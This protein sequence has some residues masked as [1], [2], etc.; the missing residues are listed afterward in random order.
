MERS[1]RLMVKRVRISEWCWFVST[2]RQHLVMLL[3]RFHPLRHQYSPVTLHAGA[4]A[5]RRHCEVLWKI[6]GRARK[7]DHRQK[8]DGS[9][10]PQAVPSLASRTALILPALLFCRS[11]WLHVNA[12]TALPKV[13]ARW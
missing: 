1:R 4:W 2:F 8:N 9:T 3:P 5:L 13:V 10:I 6:C 11:S 7:L 12:L